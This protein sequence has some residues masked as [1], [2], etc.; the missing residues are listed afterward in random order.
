MDPWM[1]QIIA[2]ERRDRWLRA[3]AAA[4][5]PA[6]E[7]AHTA[8]ASRVQTIGREEIAM[9]EKGHETKPKT[10]HRLR[11]RLAERRARHADRRARRKAHDI[12]G[13]ARQAESSLYKGGF[14]TT[15][16]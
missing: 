11:R 14:F 7:P 6:G 1:H 15:K 8:H 16:H 2:L 4:T 9:A 3:A 10:L 5:C 12:E 13:A